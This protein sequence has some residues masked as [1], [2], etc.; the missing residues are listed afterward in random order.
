MSEVELSRVMVVDDHPIVREG[1]RDALVLSGE[2]EVVGL[3]GDGHEAVRKARELR[4]DIILMDIMMPGKDG[5]EACREVLDEFPETRVLVLTASTEEEAVVESAAAG[6][7]GYLLKDTRRED[8]LEAVRE[9]ARGRI[10]I[11]PD[12]LRRAFELVRCGSR[13]GPARRRAS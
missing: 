13:S 10:S 1:L 6:A 4:P 3:A 7:A 9:V 2:F 8:L 11:S 12:L 5:I